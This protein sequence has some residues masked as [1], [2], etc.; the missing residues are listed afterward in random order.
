MRQIEAL[1]L[2][3]ITALVG[4]EM[5]ESVAWVPFW[6]AVV[7][8]SLLLEWEEGLSKKKPLTVKEKGDRLPMLPRWSEENKHMVIASNDIKVGTEVHLLDGVRHA[9]FDGGGRWKIIEAPR[10]TACG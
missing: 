6:L 3:S 9:T 1:T 10:S 2:A 4:W 8:P 7:V 5:L